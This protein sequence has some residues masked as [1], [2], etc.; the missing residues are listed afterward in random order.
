M[1][2]GSLEKNDCP[3]DYILKE[4]RG[5]FICSHKEVLLIDKGALD[6]TYLL[7]DELH[8][9]LKQKVEYKEDRLLSPIV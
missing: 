8:L 4:S 3:D 9:Y 2:K 1:A 6:N 7:I 5:L